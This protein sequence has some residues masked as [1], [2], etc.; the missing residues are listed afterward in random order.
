[1]TPE[2]D[3]QTLAIVDAV[4]AGLDKRQAI[5]RE[6]HA[7]HHDYVAM[8]IE[9]RRQ[10][11]ERREKVIQTVGGWAIIAMLAAIGSAVWVFINDHVAMR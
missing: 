10:W 6:T 11:L 1:M 5:D 2:H 3:E 4:L 9:E 8:R 7:M